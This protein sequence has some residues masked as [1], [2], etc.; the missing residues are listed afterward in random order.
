V[1]NPQ[2]VLSR[3]SFSISIST[4]CPASLGGIHREQMVNI[5]IST[6]DLSM[7]FQLRMG[8]SAAE[9]FFQS[10]SDFGLADSYGD[11]GE[12]SISI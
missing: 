10:N 1:I 3:D 9:A 8:R 5:E 11:L 7:M 4:A 12:I 6:N 2:I